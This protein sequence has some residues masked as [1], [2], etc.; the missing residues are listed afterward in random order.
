MNRGE[1]QLWTLT[2]NRFE[3]AQEP[4][5]EALCVLGNGYF[6]TRGA[7]CESTA[8]KIHYPGTYIAGVYNKL[9]TNLA[10]RTVVN[11]DLV[12][13]PN[14]LFITFRIGNDE[15]FMPSESEIV[16]YRQELNMYHGVLRRILKFKDKNG[17]ITL[18]DTERFVHMKEPHL[19]AIKY[20]I[21]PQNYN[22]WITVRVML[23]G[24]VE[25]RG[26]ERYRQLNS[27]HLLPYAYGNFKDNGIYLAMITSQ[28]K[29]IIAESCKTLFF[30]NG[31][32]IKP[33]I[34]VVRR[35]LLEGKERIG[36]EFRF[37]A[38]RGSSYQIQK[39]V[40]IY[41]SNDKK[42][43][44]P[45]KMSIKSL[46]AVRSYDTLVFSHKQ[47]WHDLWEKYDIEIK[48]DRFSQWILRIHTFHL[49]QT[50]SPNTVDLDVGI[51]ARGL[52]GEAY[53]GHIFWD[54]IFIMH[55]YDYHLPHVSRSLLLYRYRRLNKA[56]EYARKFGYRGAMYPWQS[57]S[58][59]EEE[60]QT[61]HLNPLS[62]K[63][64]PDYSSYQRHVSFAI[65]YNVW[66]YWIRTG[67]YD[68][69]IN[70]GAEMI[71]SIAQFGASLVKYERRDKRFH[72][73]RVMGPDEFHEKYP[74]SKKPGLKDNAYTNFMIVWTILKA[75]QII[76]ILP[77]YHRDRIFKKI[78]LDSKELERWE[79]ITYKMAIVINRKGIIAQFDG[80]FDLKELDWKAYIQ[81]YGNVQRM[82]RIL[83]A[84]GKSPDEYKVTKQADVL[85]IFYLFPIEEVKYIFNRLGYDFSFRM[86]RKNYEYYV[87]RTSHGS[88]LS[89]VAYCYVAHV[90]GKKEVSWYWFL[91]VLESD[92]YDTQRGTT[93]EGIH[94]GV[95]GGSIDI[96]MRAFLGLSIDECVCFNPSLPK[97][98]EKLRLKFLYKNVWYDVCVMRRSIEIRPDS[99]DKKAHVE[100]KVNHKKIKIPIGRKVRLKLK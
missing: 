46:Q 85:M 42:I 36:Q 24:A 14:W 21:I 59:G 44:D 15:W 90:L 94:T 4:L 82:D 19:G 58:T 37:F 77:S 17:R 32:K 83:K 68:F 48:N 64:G 3:P 93:P 16:F 84:E 92:V 80:Y 43:K 18:V 55:F 99:S 52:H 89:K 86:L 31:K 25:N 81:E 72:T 74:H 88:T 11:E 87:K 76:D 26:V 98:W 78:G 69:L 40:S 38:R 56:R 12:N 34:K 22:D 23:D 45:I 97:K 60:T 5:R 2:Y 53:R 66:H 67:D 1:L 50:A 61:F 51:P 79:E 10:G 13:C 35:R 8:S 33:S 57:A 27:K 54:E 95:M 6:A 91:D 100:V 70:F 28:S 63:W 49:L 71:L 29:I 47:T 96:V 73:Y 65:A 75:M 20:T 9:K 30:V 41:T 7:A 62:G 39:I